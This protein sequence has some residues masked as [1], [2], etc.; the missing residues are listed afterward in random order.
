MLMGLILGIPIVIEASF[1]INL[2]VSFSCKHA[3]S[4]HCGR[5][6]MPR[7]MEHRSS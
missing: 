7:K 6:L 1:C 4:V 5:I 2:E 3:G